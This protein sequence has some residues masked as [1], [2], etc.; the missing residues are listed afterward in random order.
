MEEAE[1]F[2]RIGHQPTIYA[3]VFEEPDEVIF[4]AVMKNR[5]SQVMAWSSH[6]YLAPSW[7]KMYDVGKAIVDLREI[8]KRGEIEYG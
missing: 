6:L 3:Q 2:K 4:T 8:E 1:P 5:L 7:G